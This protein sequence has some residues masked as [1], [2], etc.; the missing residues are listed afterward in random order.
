MIRKRPSS[1]LIALS[2]VLLT[3]SA[4]GAA[5]WWWVPTAPTTEHRSPEQLRRVASRDFHRLRQQGD[6]EQARVKLQELMEWE[7]IVYGP[8]HFELAQSQTWQG[9]LCEHQGQWAEAER[10]YREALDRLQQQP[11]TIRWRA[12]AARQQWLR[13]R[14]IRKL[15]PDNREA[16]RKDA[17]WYDTILTHQMRLGMAPGTLLEQ[18]RQRAAR[19]RRLLG[20]DTPDLAQLAFYQGVLAE[21]A[22]NSKQALAAAQENVTLRG[23]LYGPQNPSNWGAWDYLARVLSKQKKYRD[24]AA[25][26]Q[27]AAEMLEQ[28]GERRAVDT[29]GCWY[30]AGAAFTDAQDPQA[31]IAAFRRMKKY[32]LETL[33]ETH[34]QTGR[35]WYCLGNALANY[36]NEESLGCLQRAAA[37]LKRH[38]FKRHI[39]CSCLVALGAALTGREDAAQAR[40]LLEEALR[41]SESLP[42]GGQLLRAQAIANLGVVLAELNNHTRGVALLKEAIGIREQVLGKDHPRTAQAYALLGTLY[43]NHGEQPDEGRRWYQKALDAL[44]ASQGEQDPYYIVNLHNLAVLN[45]GLGRLA[46]A[47]Q[48]LTE[49]V[50]LG[51][52][53]L[54]AKAHAFVGILLSYGDTRYRLGDKEGA[55]KLFERALKLARHTHP[56]LLTTALRHAGTLSGATGRLKP[57]LASMRESVRVALERADYELGLLSESEMLFLLRL[58]QLDA[59]V[60]LHVLHQ[61][62]PSRSREAYEMLWSVR[63]LATHARN[64]RRRRIHSS[65]S[66][67]RLWQ[68][69]SDRTREVS[70]WM[71]DASPEAEQKLAAALEKKRRLATELAT[72]DVL[73]ERTQRVSKA[74][75]QDLL[76]RLPPEVAVIEF[77]DIWRNPQIGGMLADCIPEMYYQAFVIGAKPLEG[78]RPITWGKLGPTEAI[79]QQVRRFR[80]ENALST[81]RGLEWVPRDPELPPAPPRVIRNP[82]KWL[83]SQVWEPLAPHLGPCR[84]VVIVGARGLH[85]LPWAALPGRRADRYFLEESPAVVTAS[86]GQ[87][88]YDLLTRSRPKQQK[89]VAVGGVNYDTD[90]PPSPTVASLYRGGDP[91]P[92]S[93]PRFP[94]LKGSAAE[95]SRI[96]REWFADR[97]VVLSGDDASEEQ[98]RKLL[99]Q[100]GFIHLSTHGFFADDTVRARLNP[101]AR[102]QFPL[103][104][105]RARRVQVSPAILC[106]LAL[107]SANQKP[108]VDELGRPL[109]DDGIFTAEEVMGLDLSGTNLAVLSACDT[110]LGVVSSVDEGVLGLSRA[111][112]NAGARSCLSSLWM[113]DDVTTQNLMSKFYAQLLERQREKA[114]ALRAAQ[115]AMLRG[116][117]LPQKMRPAFRNRDGRIRVP[118]RYWAAWQLYGDWR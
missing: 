71:Y 46:E 7:R 33:G 56:R 9:I 79:D 84:T 101:S 45:M 17:I 78:K 1:R 48:Q 4:V 60:Y 90:A 65:P 98:V 61:L 52:Q 97:A 35:A 113:V 50:R 89:L 62:D 96:A 12:A 28:Y 5:R 103:V 82:G 22:G 10:H 34:Y 8:E 38:P 115:L 59:K 53:H 102:P 40:L 63:G 43:A 112:V 57:A 93:R 18:I 15:S 94:Y 83:R 20:P 54:G 64:V 104:G 85:R 39:Y 88:L 105:K 70:Q 41:L 13:V 6:F 107:R 72:A 106:G 2:A 21:R 31:A 32:S 81:G 87:Q 42:E 114:E 66:A 74:R 49:A 44:R 37:I 116:G 19:I 80:L 92:D 77:V 111:F 67:R 16:V 73:L 69:W 29:V 86:N 3:V 24:A 27:R 55:R 117:L 75:L 68:Q 51:E 108:P 14:R 100:A 36:D 26:Y 110:G 118:A 109:A 25:A 76:E 47:D 91:L 95:V 58:L 99:P 23:R 11:E 30:G